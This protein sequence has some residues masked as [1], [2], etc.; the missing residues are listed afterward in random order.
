MKLALCLF[1]YSPFS[2]LSRDFMRVLRE[3]QQRGH[4]VVVYA[5]QWDGDRPDDINL[6]EL[7]TFRRTNHAMNA[8]YYR[9][10]KS[11]LDSGDHDIVIGFNKM[12]GL[13][14]YYGADYCYVGRVSPKYPQLYRLTPRYRQMAAFERAVFGSDSNTQVLSLSERERIVY[15]QYYETADQR[16]H[17]LP[18]TLDRER[19]LQQDHGHVRASVREEL[20]AGE[21]EQLVLFIG[22]GFKTKGLD[23]AIAAFATLDD[24]TRLRSRLLVIGEDESTAFKRQANRLRVSDRVSFMGGRSD[25]PQLLAA[26]DLLLHPAYNEN[27]G[28]V[29][30]EAIAAGLP[31]LATDVCGYASHIEKADAGAV[32]HSPFRQETLNSAL[33]DMLSSPLRAQWRSNG[34]RYG[35]D[36]ALYTMPETVVDII[37]QWQP[38]SPSALTDPHSDDTTQHFYLRSDLNSA[39]ASSTDI[40]TIMAMQGENFR[41]APGRRTIR[42][43]R[44]DKGYF[45]KAHTGVGWF[46]IV[47]NISYGRL[48]VIGAAN[49]WHGIHWITRLG[50]DTLNVAGYGMSG[51]NPAKR[52]S[53]IITDEIANTISL[54]DYLVGPDRA[55]FTTP[56]TL[57]IKRRLIRQVATV[58]CKMHESG[59]NHR[60]FYLCHFLMRTPVPD[61]ADPTIHL[62]DLH[63]MQLRRRTPQRWVT[64][65]IAGLYYSCMDSDL[66]RRDFLRFIRHYRG[67]SLREVFATEKAFWEKVE[68]KARVLYQAEARRARRVTDTYA[69]SSTEAG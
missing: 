21:D 50:I 36:P 27:T 38:P 54:E 64:K 25:I 69:E 34:L 26:G 35:E 67:Q 17:I 5:S 43:N 3:C 9:K 28:T 56:K 32:L 52:R 12:P 6:V 58:A 48:P 37:E 10:L 13:D 51:G 1:K 42:F 45:L 20:S 18:P 23:R 29:L 2:G 39:L 16:F 53:F 4:E 65:D 68:F 40:E 49:E 46:E 19:R 24:E 14:I 61:D 44:N 63:R 33:Y 7:K 55:R 57:S 8:A 47:K 30:L 11:H 22:S 41:E 15:R 62:I 31:V 66:T 59:A 60:D